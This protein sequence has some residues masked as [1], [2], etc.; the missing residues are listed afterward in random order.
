MSLIDLWNAYSMPVGT[1]LG[2]VGGIYGTVLKGRMSSRRDH[3]E[4]GR[5]ALELVAR[6]TEREARIDAVATAYMD[7][8]DAAQRQRIEDMD[9]AQEVYAAAISARLIIL[10]L[11]ARAGRPP[12]DFPALPPY[13]YPPAEHEAAPDSAPAT[14]ALAADTAEPRAENTHG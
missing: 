13:P 5:Q 14:G 12:R 6:A 4:A 3:L 1:I 10:E 9:R 8:L 11:D 2:A 7:R